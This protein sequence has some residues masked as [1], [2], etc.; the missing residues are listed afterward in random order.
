MLQTGSAAGGG[1]GVPPCPRP[2]SCR[3]RH[4]AKPVSSVRLRGVSTVQCNRLCVPRLCI[5]SACWLPGGGGVWGPWAAPDSP[6]RPQNQSYRE[7]KQR[8]R[9]CVAHLLG[10]V[11][12]VRAGRVL[13]R[14]TPVL[15]PFLLR[16]QGACRQVTRGPGAPRGGPATRPRGWREPHPAAPSPGC[17]KGWPSPVPQGQRA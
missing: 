13:Q 17:P 8:G 10:G 7:P 12:P 9:H 2:L 5:V 16:G 15:V 6:P 11:R 1:P 3:S 4:S 14:S